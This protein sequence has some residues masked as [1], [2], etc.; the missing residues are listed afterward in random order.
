MSPHP[1]ADDP[2]LSPT[3]LHRRALLGLFASGAAALVVAGCGGDG[4]G[5]VVGG[6]DQRPE[7]ADAVKVVGERYRSLVPAEDDEATLESLLGLE[8]GT[9]TDEAMLAAL[10][11][12]VRNDFATSDTVM[13]DGWILS[14][15]EARAAALLSLSG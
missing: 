2:P 12:Q 6:S 13:I 4:S 10:A 7:P 11:E 5:D 8:A 14:V 9:A 15:T 1:T 3:P